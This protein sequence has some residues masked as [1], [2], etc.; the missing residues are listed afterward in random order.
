M[1]EGIIPAV[2][3][4][5]LVAV[6]VALLLG[7]LVV[8]HGIRR[9]LMDRYPE[10]IAAFDAQMTARPRDAVNAFAW[11]GRHRDIGDDQLTAS[12]MRF[13]LLAVGGVACFL[14]APF[15]W[16]PIEALLRAG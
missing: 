3:A 8:R 14:A 1:D 2:S 9:V 5:A 6:S 7:H 4:A 15:A 13:R 10:V 11:S 12:V 16:M